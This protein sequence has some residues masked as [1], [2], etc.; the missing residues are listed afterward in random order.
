MMMDRAQTKIVGV[1]VSFI[2]VAIVA[3]LGIYLL[4]YLDQSITITGP[5]AGT[6]QVVLIGAA[7]AIVLAIG[8][9]TVLVTAVLI[10]AGRARG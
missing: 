3:R 5:F 8:G 9:T 2:V 10:L 6:G 4:A 1:V 7:E